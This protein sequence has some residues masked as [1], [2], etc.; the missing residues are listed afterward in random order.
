M[1]DTDPDWQCL[2]SGFDHGVCAHQ[3]VLK[4]AQYGILC[5]LPHR[6]FLQFEG[7]STK[8]MGSV[9]VILNPYIQLKVSSILWPILNVTS[10]TCGWSQRRG[11]VDG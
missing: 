9:F 5:C 7:V 8:I 1:Q 4:V 6:C 11:V 10:S 3:D 2:H